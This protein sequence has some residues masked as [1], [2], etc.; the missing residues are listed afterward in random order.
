MLCL[1]PRTGHS[2]CCRR[3][4]CVRGYLKTRYL[5]YLHSLLQY[6]GKN[7]TLSPFVFRVQNRVPCPPN[8]TRGVCRWVA[9]WHGSCYCNSRTVVLACF[10]LLQPRYLRAGTLLAMATLVPHTGIVLACPTMPHQTPPWHA[11]C[12]CNH[13]AQHP[14]LKYCV[15]NATHYLRAE[16]SALPV[17]LSIP[18]SVLLETM[19]WLN[20]HSRGRARTYKA[21]M[22][23]S[24]S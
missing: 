3:S 17:P 1:L 12:Y 21:R 22:G 10:V 5:N 19:R 11:S 15:K 6:C 23:H 2:C 13:Y 16:I 8:R 18:L 9:G 24:S 4:C 14:L 7:T 20:L